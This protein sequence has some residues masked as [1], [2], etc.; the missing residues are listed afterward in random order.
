MN[1]KQPTVD[2]SKFQELHKHKGSSNYEVVEIIPK[3]NES[4]YLE[5]DSITN[6]LYVNS[7]FEPKSKNSDEIE[8]NTLRLDLLGNLEDSYKAHSKLKDGTMWNSDYYVNWII[9]GD[10]IKHR[11]ID[12]FSKK[13]ID[14]H[15]YEFEVKEKKPEKW[16]EKFTETYNRSQYVFLNMSDYYFKM[17]NVWYF[18][19]G[20]DMG[21]ANKINIKEKYPP[22]ENQNIRI[23]E[24]ENLAPLWY[25]E[26][27]KERDTTLIKMMD[28]ESTFYKEENFGLIKQGYSA[29]WWY[30]E[31]YMPLGDTLRIKRFSDFEDPDLELYKVPAAYGGREDVLFIVQ[32]PKDSHMEQVGGMYV[33]RPRDAKQPERRYDSVSC[34]TNENGEQYIIK[35]QDTTEYT[36]WNKENKR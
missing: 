6:N 19:D 28:Y 12:P 7:F 5:I 24:L 20:Y 17:D 3:I 30:L 9:N 35:S 2:H 32:K 16:L 4:D 23:V 34:G 25:H 21:E 18:I 33:I 27:F 29:G 36:E 14:S 10:T 11:Y 1:S 13:K 31:I 8:Y 15:P 26:G 22:K